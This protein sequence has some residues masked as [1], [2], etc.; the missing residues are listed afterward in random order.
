[1][2]T[3]K[4]PSGKKRKFGYGQKGKEEAEKFAKNT[5]GKMTKAKPAK[6]KPRYG[7]A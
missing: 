3:V 5:G 7:R 1:M 4:T 2:P 6:R